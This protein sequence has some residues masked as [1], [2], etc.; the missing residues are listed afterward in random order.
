MLGISGPGHFVLEQIKLLDDANRLSHWMKHAPASCGGVDTLKSTGTCIDDVCKMRGQVRNP[1]VDV[2]GIGF[3]MASN[4]HNVEIN[5]SHNAKA[6]AINAGLVDRFKDD[7]C[8]DPPSDGMM[9]LVEELG[10]VHAQEP[11]MARNALPD[12]ATPAL[13][14]LGAR[15]VYDLFSFGSIVI[16]QLRGAQPILHS[17]F[18]SIFQFDDATPSLEESQRAYM[19]RNGA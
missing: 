7:F 4:L 12:M 9:S 2:Y 18:P 17:F 19:I 3:I 5:I 6:K 14:L 1:D 13:A 10:Q 15:L 11:V 16:P 8:I